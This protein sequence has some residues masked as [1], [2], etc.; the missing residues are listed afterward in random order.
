MEV[1]MVQGVRICPWV[2]LANRAEVRRSEGKRRGPL[3]LE[4]GRGEG[5]AGKRR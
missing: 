4:G 3:I 2:T 1:P 5:G